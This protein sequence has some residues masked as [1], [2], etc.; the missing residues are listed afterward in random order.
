MQKYPVPSSLLQSVPS[1]LTI[2]SLAFAEAPIRPPRPPPAKAELPSSPPPHHS[3]TRNREEGSPGV[4]S[5]LLRLQTV[6]SGES[7]LC[8]LRS[9]PWSTSASPTSQGTNEL[10]WHS[11]GFFLQERQ[12]SMSQGQVPAPRGL[13]ASQRERRGGLQG[14]QAE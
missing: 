9:S 12:R 2:L 10:L 7:L 5:R 4:S 8:H 1:P 3:Q 14:C 6:A 13:S 11:G